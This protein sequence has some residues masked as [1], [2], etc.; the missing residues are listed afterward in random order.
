MPGWWPRGSMIPTQHWHIPTYLLVLKKIPRIDF[1]QGSQ[2][3]LEKKKGQ[4]TN[5]RTTASSMKIV[6]SLIFKN[7]IKSESKNQNQR[8]FKKSKNRPTLHLTVDVINPGNSKMPIWL[9]GFC[10]DFSFFS[11]HKVMWVYGLFI[12]RTNSAGVR[13]LWAPLVL[14]SSQEGTM[15]IYP[16]SN[17][18]FFRDGPNK[19]KI[20]KQINSSSFLFSSLMLC[21]DKSI[22]ITFVLKRGK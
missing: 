15:L 4:R 17:L 12:N 20:P 7:K 8:F 3:K 19:T 18:L 13:F 2:K 1:G 14:E 16:A 21:I 11:R 5:G 6:N 22:V 9:L 10:T